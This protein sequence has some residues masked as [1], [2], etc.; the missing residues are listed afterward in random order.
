MF[1]KER[2]KASPYLLEIHSEI[3]KDGIKSR[4]TFKITWERKTGHD[5]VTAR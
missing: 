3:F 2:E 1:K 5:L 4:M